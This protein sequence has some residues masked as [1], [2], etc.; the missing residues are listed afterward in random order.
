VRTLPLE[1]DDIT[2]VLTTDE[3]DINESTDRCMYYAN[4]NHM[5]PVDQP[6]EPHYAGAKY[7]VQVK[8][9]TG[10]V[11]YKPLDVIAADD[12][13]TCAV[14]ARD[15]DFL[16]QPDWKRFKKLATR[17][18]QI[19]RLIR[20]AKMHSYKS[21]LWYKFGYRIPA[22]FDEALAFD[23]A[24]GNSKWQDATALQMKQLFDYDCFETEASMGRLPTLEGIRR[25][26]GGSVLM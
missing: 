4:L 9:E 11:T 7:N 21:A 23:M 12:P 10:E 5:V 25:Y 20:Q 3:C 26:E 2:A 19:L 1:E 13:V 16:D 15:N 24:N 6:G 22:T 17:E 14:Y 8:W 18:K